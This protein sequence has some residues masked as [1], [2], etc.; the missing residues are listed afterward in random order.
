MKLDKFLL[1]MSL[2]ECFIAALYKIELPFV[3]H[4]LQYLIVNNSGR[5]VKYT[6]A[7]EKPRL[8]KRSV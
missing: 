4:K 8:C 7:G 1:F 3:L 5:L 2:E 6:N